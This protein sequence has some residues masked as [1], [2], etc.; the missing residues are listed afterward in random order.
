MY[1]RQAHAHG[2]RRA[3]TPGNGVR[4]VVKLEVEEYLGAALPD[5]RH[6]VR[7]GRGEELV[8]DLV[9]AAAL[10]EPV[11]KREGGRGRWKVQRHDRRRVHAGHCNVPRSSP[12]SSTPCARHHDSSSDT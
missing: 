9:E 1:C 7:T 3:N 10:A 11:D 6:Y 12:T 4:D 2:D 5:L 8:A